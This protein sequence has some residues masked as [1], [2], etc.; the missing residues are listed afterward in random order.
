MISIKANQEAILSKDAIQP[1]TTLARA[2]ESLI[3]VVKACRPQITF[4]SELPRLL[5][6]SPP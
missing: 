3:R 6:Q 4:F 5:D 2:I 1:S